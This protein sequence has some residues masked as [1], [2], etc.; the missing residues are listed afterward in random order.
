MSLPHWEYFLSLES[1]LEDCSKYVEFTS[2]N[3]K[4]YSIEF[5]KIILLASAEFDTVAKELCKIINPN[6]NLNGINIDVYADMILSRYPKLTTMET[7]ISRYGLNF[8]PWENWSRGN[9]PKW[10]KDY[11]KIKHDRT[12]NFQEANLENAFSSL[13]GLFIG[14]LYLYETQYGQNQAEIDAFFQPRLLSLVDPN[15]TGLE[16][17]SITISFNLA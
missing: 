16:G 15:P 12:T 1:D 13:S 5:A 8:K 2:T 14:I 10:W 9:S 11:N 7:K 17:A 6:I 3:Y 4:T